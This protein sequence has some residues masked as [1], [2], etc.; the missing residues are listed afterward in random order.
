MDTSKLRPDTRLVWEQLQDHPGLH[1]FVLI[2]GT[3]LTLRIAHRISEDLDFAYPATRLPL[4][5]MN[6][7]LHA[8]QGPRLSFVPNQDPLAVE[9]ALNAGNELENYQQDFI[10]NE[11]VKV[12]FFAPEADLNEVLGSEPAA[13]LRVATLDE[14]FASKALVCADRSKTRDWFDL[15]VMMTQHGYAMEDLYNVFERL[16]R[17]PKFNIASS[18][19]RACH[20]SLSDEGY[21]QLLDNAPSLE[22]MRS[23][24]SEQLDLLEIKLARYR[25]E[26]LARSGQLGS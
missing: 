14:I 17:L 6:A 16:E 15:Y 10:A 1:G 11:T 7:F 25:F 12:T 21:E 20:P 24:F 5:Q 3:A 23:Y 19:L 22:S 4:Q 13:K 26:Q 9:E 8:A 2:G 18:R